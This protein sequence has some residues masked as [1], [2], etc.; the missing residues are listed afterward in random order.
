M[1]TEALASLA[2]LTFA[3]DTIEYLY[4]RMHAVG[5]PMSFG[6]GGNA[7]CGNIAGQTA[8]ECV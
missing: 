7:E 2:L 6:L 4:E 1:S 5:W 3:F 8:L